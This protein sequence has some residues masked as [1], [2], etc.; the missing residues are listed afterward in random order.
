MIHVQ[1]P[2]Y[3]IHSPEN[4]IGHKRVHFIYIL[5]NETCFILEV[6]RFDESGNIVSFIIL[7]I[8]RTS[9]AIQSVLERSIYGTH[10]SK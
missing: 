7:Q 4:T 5:L 6:N 3:Q 8:V 10:R 1:S 2:C 9:G